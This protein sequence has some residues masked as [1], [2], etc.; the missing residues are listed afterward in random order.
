MVKS[1]TTSDCYVDILEMWWKSK[2]KELNDQKDNV[3]KLVINLDN[4]PQQNSHRTQFMK[5]IQDFSNKSKIAIT[6]AYY[7]PYHSKYN[8]VERPFGSLEKHWSGELLS[9]EDDVIGFA[10]T[11]QWAGKN[12]K[13]EVIRNRPIIN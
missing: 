10:K 11:M 9:S 12:P 3:K 8:P 1:N 5:R 2:M 7:P 13:V 6:L 4:G